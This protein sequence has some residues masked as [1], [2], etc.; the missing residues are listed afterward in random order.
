LAMSSAP[1]SN[2][3]MLESLKL[4][5]ALEQRRAELPFVD[6]LLSTHKTAHG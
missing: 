2:E 1:M 5:D 6:T 3:S 4:I